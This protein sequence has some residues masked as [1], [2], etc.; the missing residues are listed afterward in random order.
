MAARTGAHWVRLGSAGPLSQNCQLWV[1]HDTPVKI[2]S[3]LS[4]E[5]YD[6]F[7]TLTY[8]KSDIIVR[9]VYG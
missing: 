2:F 3:A 7:P 4:L 9:Y 5:F 6:E 8:V 1:Q